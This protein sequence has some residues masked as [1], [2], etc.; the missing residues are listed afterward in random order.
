[1]IK[2]NKRTLT[3]NKNKSGQSDPFV[4]TRKVNNPELIWN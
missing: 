4:L 2:S 1:M 3:I